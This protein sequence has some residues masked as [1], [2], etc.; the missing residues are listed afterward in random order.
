VRRRDLGSDVAPRI[1][2]ASRKRGLENG[3]ISGRPQA[4]VDRAD[5]KPA[6]TDRDHEQ[7]Q[8]QAD[9]A[10]GCGSS[11]SRRPSSAFRHD[12]RSAARKQVD[13]EFTT[14]TSRADTNT[15]PRQG[16]EVAL[17]HGL[18]GRGDELAARNAFPT[19]ERQHGAG[20]PIQSASPSAAARAQHVAGDD[21]GLG[22]PLGAAVRT[23]IEVQDLQHRGRM[24]R[25]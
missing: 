24:M 10:A 4:P 3:Q 8:D 23:K 21:A 15:M 22:Q 6:L 9:H 19:T 20:L 1:V 11:V 17:H 12:A 7:Q 2:G 16:V 25:R 18:I 13:D 5:K 14:M